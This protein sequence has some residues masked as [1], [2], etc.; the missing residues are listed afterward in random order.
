MLIMEEDVF[1]SFLVLIGSFFFVE[2]KVYIF[3]IFKSFWLLY[4]DFIVIVNMMV[5]LMLLEAIKRN[6]F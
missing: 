1:Y 5:I 6:Y 3:L 2:L 4:K